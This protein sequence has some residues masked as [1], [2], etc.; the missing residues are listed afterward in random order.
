MELLLS[1]TEN[2]MAADYQQESLARRG[3][4][5][6]EFRPQGRDEEGS[7]SSAARI[8]RDYTPEAAFAAAMI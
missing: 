4:L 7:G 2:A 5:S 1:Q 3:T 6:T 8:L